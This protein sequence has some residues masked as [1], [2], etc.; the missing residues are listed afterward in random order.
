MPPSA[1]RKQPTAAKVA[2]VNAPLRWPNMWLAKS[3]PVIEAQSTGMNRLSARGLA[4]WMARATNS[5]PVPLAPVI[6]TLD[7]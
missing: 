6:I 4:A 3:V 7:G 5:L 2:P 1:A